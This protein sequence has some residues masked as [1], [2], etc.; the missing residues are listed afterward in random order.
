MGT[1]GT[2]G[3][4]APCAPSLFTN[5]DGQSLYLA[6]YLDQFLAA[7]DVIVATD[8]QGLG[9]GGVHP[10][11]VGASEAMNSLDAVRAA[12]HLR[13]L[14]LS[15]NVVVV[16]HSQGGQ[17]ALF[18]GEIAPSYAPDL[19]LLGVVAIAPA[20]N[21]SAA[22]TAADDLAS[23]GGI[24]DN[25]G[26]LDYVA[27]ALWAWTH[28]YPGLP[29][30]S[31]FTSG[32][33][34]DMKTAAG[35]CLPQ[36]ALS[37]LAAHAQQLFRPGAVASPAVSHYAALNNPGQVRSAAPIL[38][39]QGTADTTVP[40]AVT[41]FFVHSQACA[42]G[43]QVAYSL[44]PGAG[45]GGVIAPARSEILSYVAAR[46]DSRPAPSVCAAGNTGPVGQPIPPSGV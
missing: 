12:S 13:G 43:D 9:T 2:T 28:T 3:L 21:I 5:L 40:Y 24:S 45:H 39:V 26:D 25:Q 41:T 44:Y 10:Y 46:F 33:V 7:N 42:V 8:Y 18:T 27:M 11:L 14:F 30:T 22:V 29:V 32:G 17:A 20:T 35:G 23:R 6:P 31:I 19:R 37:L 34:S 38:V 36:I 15:R 4:S 16:G 1:H